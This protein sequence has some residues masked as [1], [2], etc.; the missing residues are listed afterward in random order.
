MLNI[1]F[2]T[3]KKKYPLLTD[4][5]VSFLN[6][7][8]N[9]EDQKLLF[10]DLENSR[11]SFNTKRNY[12]II[13]ILFL[14]ILILALLKTLNPL[15]IFIYWFI[16]FLI[17]KL[18]LHFIINT[19]KSIKDEILPIFVKEFNENIEY[20]KT[21]SLYKSSISELAWSK[22]WL[23]KKYDR[24][25]YTEDSIR[26]ILWEDKWFDADWNKK[27]SIE[28]VW[29]EIKT[30]QK[31]KNKNWTYYVT[32]NHCYIMKVDFKNPR[33]ILKNWIKLLEDISENYLKKFLVVFWIQFTI[34]ISIFWWLAWDENT[35]WLSDD[36]FMLAINNIEITIV[37]LVWMFSFIW[38]LYSFI[39]WKNR[40][41]LENID[42]EKEFD[43]Y[44]E[45]Q[46]ESRKLLTPSFMYR[47]VDFVNKINKKR[48]YEMYF[49]WS[50]FYLKYDILK[51]NSYKNWFKYSNYWY[52]EFKSN[53]SLESN[54][55][56]LV[57]FLL[58]IKNIESL[59]K[60]LKLFYYD[61]WMMSNE[62][63]K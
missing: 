34:L 62:I 30:S 63:I 5:D 61:K 25:D 32:N 53:N 2:N 60:D 52:M 39:K 21:W 47:L 7:F 18:V 33:F 26:Y 46:I 11:K 27:K 24:L 8:F 58:E 43:V 51:T 14:V 37:F 49:H 29:T 19:N 42:F 55:E 36:L 12:L 35:D 56:S 16:F 28:I 23:L 22:I 31:R 10:E 57:E 48:V 6:D 41:R 9:R 44:C 3:I 38:I 40:V 50:T 45:D 20:N 1:D 59:S 15:V 54:L 4:K 17:Y 13:A